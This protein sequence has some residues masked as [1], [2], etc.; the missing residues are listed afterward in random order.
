MMPL[1][2]KTAVFCLIESEISYRIFNPFYSAFCGS[3]CPTA[4]PDCCIFSLNN[5]LKVFLL[6]GIWLLPTPPDAL[7]ATWGTAG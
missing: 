2:G 5:K 4:E 6:T 1:F 3:C 7:N